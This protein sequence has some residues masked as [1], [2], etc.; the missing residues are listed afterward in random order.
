MHASMHASKATLKLG[1]DYNWNK[2]IVS[3]MEND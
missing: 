2:H 1:K 3:L